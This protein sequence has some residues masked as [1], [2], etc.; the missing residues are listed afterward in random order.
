MANKNIGLINCTFHDEPQAAY[1][2]RD[3]KEKLYIYCD[4]CGITSP[5]AAKFQTYILKNMKK[6]EVDEEGEE[7]YKPEAPEATPE[8]KKQQK[9]DWLL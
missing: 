5:R 3:R 2:R 9:D 6:I 7:L 8:V 1:V 4:D